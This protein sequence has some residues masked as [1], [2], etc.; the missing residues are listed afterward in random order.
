[1]KKVIY[2]MKEMKNLIAEHKLYF[3]APLF[4]LLACVGILFFK[5]GP[6]VIMAFIYAGL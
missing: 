3:L 6:S 4:V 2:V 5:L 1:M